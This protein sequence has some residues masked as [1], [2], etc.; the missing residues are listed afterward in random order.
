MY[1][2]QE[3]HNSHGSKITSQLDRTRKATEEE[4]DRETETE[5]ETET[6]RERQKKVRK[7]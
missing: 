7:K 6:D 2:V 5:T 1:T 3:L 4:R